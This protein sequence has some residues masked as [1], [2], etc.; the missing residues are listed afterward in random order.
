MPATQRFDRIV[1]FG[2]GWMPIARGGATPE[3]KIAMLRERLKQAGRD[4][5]SVSV[6]IFGPKPDRA[7]VDGLAAVGVERAIF[8]IPSAPPDKILPMLDSYAKLAG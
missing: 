2:Q 5:L 3:T 8:I 6:S 4:P 7:T 1:E